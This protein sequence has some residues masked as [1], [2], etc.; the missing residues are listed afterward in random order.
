MNHFNFS[1]SIVKIRLRFFQFLFS[2]N[3]IEKYKIIRFVRYE[4]NKA[5]IKVHKPVIITDSKGLM[6]YRNYIK[7]SYNTDLICYKILYD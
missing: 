3:K 2:K 6:K 7:K 1:W 4:N 5:I